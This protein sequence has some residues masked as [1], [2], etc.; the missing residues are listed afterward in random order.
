M[1]SWTVAQNDDGDMDIGGTA[2]SD[3]LTDE[4]EPDVIAH[5]AGKTK[6]KKYTMYDKF[7]ST[8]IIS[9]KNSNGPVT[10]RFI[11]TDRFTHTHTHTHTICT[12]ASVPRAG[13]H[14][15]SMYVAAAVC[16]VCAFVCN[17]PYQ[18]VPCVCSTGEIEKERERERVFYKHS[19]G[20]YCS[21]PLL[22]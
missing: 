14:V 13:V 17:V 7:K 6:Y 2:S 1:A 9:E 10:Y 21:L 11:N 12:C 20:F 8:F 16:M 4:D 3:D 18:C 15:V 5:A 22:T 19:L